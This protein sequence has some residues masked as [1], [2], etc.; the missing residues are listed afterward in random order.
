MIIPTATNRSC[1]KLGKK[2]Q[3]GYANENQDPSP[4][5]L[6]DIVENEMME[7]IVTNFGQCSDSLLS[8]K[9]ISVI[10]QNDTKESLNT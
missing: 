9:V 2:V 10:K 3:G 6:W 5:F 1:W 7:K 8:N 4:L